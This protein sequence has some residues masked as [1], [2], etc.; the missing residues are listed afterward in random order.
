MPALACLHQIHYVPCADSYTYNYR[1]A[2]RAFQCDPTHL[3]LA[4]LPLQELRNFGFR[5]ALDLNRLIRKIR[6]FGRWLDERRGYFK[7]KIF[8]IKVPVFPLAFL[9]DGFQV[10]WAGNTGVAVVENFC[11]ADEA[12]YLIAQGGK[13]LTDSRITIDDKQIK[14]EYRKSQ[15]AI[16]FDPYN[17]DPAVLRVVTRAAMLLGLPADHVESVYVTRYRAGEYYKSH[18]DAYPGFDGDRLYTVLIYLNDLADEHGGGTIFEKLNI[19]VRPKCGRAVV[20]TNK[21]PDGSVHPESMHEA[22]PVTGDG[23]KW[24]IQLWFR[25]YPM[26]AVPKT[27]FDVPQARRGLP[28]KG[29]EVLPDGAW[30]P[31]KPEPGSDYAKAFS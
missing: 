12:E 9:P 23:I 16:V 3:I 15:T 13:G 21:N 7:A 8:G 28:L 11:S 19:G 1:F 4:P 5:A 14:D 31:G 2:V 27:S 26:I 20:W 29:D 6:N 10:N 30:A 18:M 24:V 25:R 22:L 17:K